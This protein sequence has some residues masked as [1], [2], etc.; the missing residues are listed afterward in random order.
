MPD[1]SA[2]VNPERGARL[3][4]YM[5]SVIEAGD[6]LP[7]IDPDT[8]AALVGMVVGMRTALIERER[9]VTRQQATA[10]A[11]RWVRDQAALWGSLAAT[12]DGERDGA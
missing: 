6:S 3:Y 9:G 2:R 12:A 5:A 1:L 8:A 10:A 11:E 7:Q 4:G